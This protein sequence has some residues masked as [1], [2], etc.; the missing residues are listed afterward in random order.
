MVVT[1]S[2]PEYWTGRCAPDSTAYLAAADALLYLG[3]N[4][5]YWVTSVD[6]AR[7]D[8]I[9]VRRGQVA[10]RPWNQSRWN[11]HATTGELG[12][13][14]RHRGLPPNELFGVGFTGQGSGM[15]S[16]GFRRLPASYDERFEPIFS[17]VADQTIGAF[18]LAMG[19]S[20]RRRARPF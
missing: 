13:L 1:G 17:G 15:T 9:E 8:V 20:R 11:Y 10:P 19:R 4:G 14:W 18:G 7:P 2:H 12:G 5:L 6:P 3:G 16:P